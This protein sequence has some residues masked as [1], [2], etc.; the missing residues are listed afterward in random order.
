MWA[1]PTKGRTIRLE[2]R[3]SISQNIARDQSYTRLIAYFYMVV[4]HIVRSHPFSVFVA[5]PSAA[6]GV[7]VW[8]FATFLFY[9]ERL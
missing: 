9:K 2:H 3:V 1:P 5:M 6:G 8:F 4:G 7:G